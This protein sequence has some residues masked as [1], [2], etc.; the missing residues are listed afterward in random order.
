MTSPSLLSTVRRG[1]PARPPIVVVYGTDGIGK[2]TFGASAPDPIILPTEDGLDAVPGAPRFP[3]ARSFSDVISA[4]SALYSEPHQ[5]RTLVVDSLD[6]LEP[7]VWAETARRHDKPSIEHFGYAKGY[8]FAD[9]VWRDVLDGL[10]AL[11]ADRGMAIVATAH[12][13][14]RQFNSPET[15]PYDRYQIKLHKRATELVREWADVIGFAHYEVF[16]QTSEGA[17]PARRGV[18]S[19]RRL[20]SVEERP[21]FQAKNRY[22]LPAELPLSWDAFAAAVA[23]AQARRAPALAAD[24]PTDD[25]RDRPRYRQPLS[26]SA[27]MPVPL[28]DAAQREL[29]AAI[30]GD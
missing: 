21:A 18:G 15:E 22:G 8:V 7:L 23:E 12:S 9:R 1:A 24:T 2:T 4:L 3:L 26:D 28:N 13:E 20:L 6:W 27:D 14:S 17:R 10:A 16:T 29:D 25:D 30:M 5:F 19:G 11:R